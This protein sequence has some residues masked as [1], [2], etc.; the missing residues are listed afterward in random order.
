MKLLLVVQRLKLF[1][2][3][4]SADVAGAATTVQ[5]KFWTSRS[6]TLMLGMKQG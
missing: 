1:V 6:T 2:Q 4:P 5:L 3:D